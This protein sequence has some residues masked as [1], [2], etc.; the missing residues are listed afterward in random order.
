MIAAMNLPADDDRFLMKEAI[1]EWNF[2]LEEGGVIPLRKCLESI[3]SPDNEMF[4]R[5]DI[6][7]R[8]EI[9]EVLRELTKPDRK[10]KQILIGSPGVGKSI[11]LFLVA[12]HQL[13]N[14]SG[15]PT[16]FIRRPEN[17]EEHTSIFFMK[18]LDEYRIQVFYDRD[19]DKGVSVWD[20]VA[21]I[22]SKY[23]DVHTRPHVPIRKDLYILY[24][25]GLHEGHP[26]LMN[27]HHYLAT[28]GGY[29]SP[30][31]ESAIYSSLVVLEG[32][33]RASLEAGLQK[34]SNNVFDAK[35]YPDLD[36]Y[37]TV[38]ENHD[39]DEYTRKMNI[40]EDIFYHTGGRIREVFLYATNPQV[41]LEEKTSMIGRIAKKDALLSILET[42]GSG[43]PNSPDRVRT[44]FRNGPRTFFG[45][46]LQIVDSQFYAQLLRD[47]CGLE[48]YYIAYSHALKAGLPTAT[49][50]H[51]EELLHR[52]F[53]K[54]PSPIVECIQSYGK[55][56]EGIDQFKKGAY[57]IPSIPN[58]ANIDAAMLTLD[59]GKLICFQYTIS[60][61]HT[62]N[63]KTFR[64]KFLRP[65]LRKLDLQ[66]DDVQV[67]FYFIVPSDVVTQFRSPAEVEENG[68]GCHVEYL[69]CSSVD[70]LSSLFERLDFIDWPAKYKKSRVQC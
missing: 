43:G 53:F 23:E 54:C 13:L 55:G 38:V 12:I 25:D 3:C 69:D 2:T 52:L 6:Y 42:R 58:F 48:D 27:P 10:R 18:K 49:G 11:L 35:L 41:W 47:R 21:F 34:L 15:T 45:D 5:N 20:A 28:S 19:V 63:P 33:S 64:T 60:K 31:G 46:C 62:F 32:W 51:F 9:I 30:Q 7:I 70:S 1:I 40:F 50:C 4:F 44:M 36:K 68:W 8:K 56:S 16:I 26:D 14:D 57:W 61:S 66:L 39:E 22:L 29:D 24:I 65:V 17:S 67:E 59:S 37:K